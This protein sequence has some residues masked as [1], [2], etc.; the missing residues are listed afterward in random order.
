NSINEIAFD[1]LKEHGFHTIPLLKKAWAELCKAYLVEAKWYYSGYIPTLNEYMDNAWISIA[2][3]LVLSHIFSSPNLTT[4]EC[5]EY[6]KEDSNL[7]YCSA[8]IFRLADDLGTS[9]DE[10]K[11]GDVPK[12]IQ[13][14]MHETGCSEVEAHEHVKKLIDA[15]WKRMN[16]EYLMSQSPL[17]LPFKHIALNLVRIAQCMYQ[18]GDNLGIEDQKANDH[19][20][21]LLVLSI[22]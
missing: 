8:I 18:Y 17:S 20:L 5:L 9:M 13:C 3:P 12:S 2:V 14:Y 6:W 21:L 22:P 11:R 1:N 16:G 15:T 7:I 19:V 4:K 10:L